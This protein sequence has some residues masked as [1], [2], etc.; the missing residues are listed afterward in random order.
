MLPRRVRGLNLRK[1]PIGEA[2]GIDLFSKNNK[3]SI[4]GVFWPSKACIGG[5]DVLKYMAAHL[6]GNLSPHS[7]FYTK[8]FIVEK[9]LQRVEIFFYFLRRK[10]KEFFPKMNEIIILYR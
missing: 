5:A 10:E 4:Q 1:S 3:L 6:R 2:G 7:L 9:I 8:P